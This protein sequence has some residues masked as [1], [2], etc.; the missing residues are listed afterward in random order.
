MHVMDSA[1]SAGMV[2]AL[3]DGFDLMGERPMAD[4]MEKGE[5]L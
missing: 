4:V 3:Q 5:G 1:D 2:V